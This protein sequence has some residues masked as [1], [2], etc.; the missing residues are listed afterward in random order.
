MFLLTDKNIKKQIWYNLNE[1]E[2]DPIQGQEMRL[3]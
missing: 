1:Y 2:H 3:Y